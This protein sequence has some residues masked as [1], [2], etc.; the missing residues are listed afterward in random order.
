MRLTPVVLC[1]VALIDPLS[2]LPLASQGR[3]AAVPRLELRLDGSEHDLSRVVH[4]S[5][6]RKGAI[7]VPQPD[8]GY[9]RV[10]DVSGAEIGRFGRNGDG[11]G[12]FRS[13]GIFRGWVGDTFW[14]A[15]VMNRRVSLWHLPDSL[16]RGIVLGQEDTPATDRSV[17][18]GRLLLPSVAGVLLDG[19]LLVA[20][21]FVRTEA[22][23]GW[24]AS[25]HDSAAYLILHATSSGRVKR[26]VAAFPP[27][28]AG[29]EQLV[30][31]RLR[32][33]PE[34]ENWFWSISP[35]ASRITDVR[36]DRER[37]DSFELLVT[38]IEPDGD[39]LFKRRLRVRSVALTEQDTDSIRK[40]N[41]ERA[42]SPA[43]KQ[44][45]NDIRMPSSFR[46][47]TRVVAGADGTTWLRMR[48]SRVK[49]Q[50]L[51]LEPNGG[52][53]GW[54]DLP[55]NFHL[56][57]AQ[58]GAVWGSETDHDGIMSVARYRIDW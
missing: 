14:Q 2:P 25:V 55:D 48:T 36:V 1:F 16:V 50:Y 53:L 17:G 20:G 27:L 54:V 26:V 42:R 13:I 45:W 38:S 41:V 40:Q 35:D 52:I 8:D 37:A 9:L 56:E 5:V 4:L 30:N 28:G 23:K 21:P 49:H 3:R 19:S 44:D 7:V 33:T 10:F 34:C 18:I 43:L 22:D 57:V 11:P 12:E 39:V 15:D 47:A 31:Q 32:P 46:P 29:C 6:S 51:V 58:K 24:A